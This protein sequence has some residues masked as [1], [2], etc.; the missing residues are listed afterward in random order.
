MTAWPPRPILRW[1]IGLGLSLIVLLIAAAGA[2]FAFAGRYDLA[3]LVSERLTAS[4]DRKV[5]I[6]SL[7]VT[8]GRWL[9]VK[10]RDFQ[11]ANLPGGSQPIMATVTAA[12]AEIEATSLLHGPLVIRKLAVDGL[13]IL[14]EPVADHRRNW[15]FGAAPRTTPPKPTDRSKFPTLL[16]AQ[17]TGDVVYRTLS[18]HSFA[19]HLDRSRIL[20]AA[21]DTPVRLT[22]DGSYNGTPLKLDADLASLDAM[23]DAATPYPTDIHVFSGDTTLHFLGTM[24]APLD[25]D[26]AKGKLELVAPTA[27]P[28]LRIAGVSGGFDASLR[29]AGPFEHDGTLWHLTRASGALNQDTITAADLKLVEG[30]HGQPDDV[31]VDLGF[32]HLNVNTL[33]AGKKKG[34]AANADIPLTVDRAPDPL[35]AAK[36]SAHELIYAGVR[37]SDVTLGGSQKPGRITVDALSLGYLGA[38]FRASGQIEPVSGS[39]GGPDSARVTANVDMQHMDVQALRKLLGAGELPLS[40]GIDGSVLVDATGATLNQAAREARL[41]AVFAMDSG[42]IGRRIIELASTDTRTIFRKA[43]GMSPITCLVGVLDIRGGIGTISPLRIRS[44]D[45]TISGRGTFDIVRHQID[46]TVASEARTTSLFALDVPL[47]ISGPFASP[48]IRPATLSAAGRTELS[49][50]DD[51]TRLLPSLQPFARRSPCLSARAG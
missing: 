20:T 25:V 24:T 37:F 16:D 48:T 21:A 49:A 26:G 46:I 17:I 35:I 23:R 10:L 44:V 43:N 9:H 40:G 18:G 32:D 41:S 8:P 2:L 31:T 1:T 42:S 6:G 28:I 5:T 3:P 15:R 27:E 33:L 50:G 38:P 36:V 39:D 12:S 45:G 7:R 4:L 29:L 34:P 11:L 30:L 19:T 14:L 51:V 22:A 47:H 13:R